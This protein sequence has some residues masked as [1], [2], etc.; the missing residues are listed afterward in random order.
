MKQEYKSGFAALAGRPNV[1]KSSLLNAFIGQKLVI[2]SEK[3]Q[4]TRNQLRGILTTGEYQIIWVDTPGLHHP[5][6]LLG[7]Q[8][9]QN[10]Y[11]ALAGV[12]LILWVLDAELGLTP[13]D[14]KVAERLR[15]FDLPVLVVWNKIDLVA[16]G[17]RRPPITGFD[18]VFKVSA[19]TREGLP[20]LLRE[21]VALLPPGPQYYPPDI[22]TDHPEK[23][24]VAEFI[25]E[26]VLQFTQDE[27]PHSVAVQVEQMKERPDGR[28]YIEA[29]IFVERDSQK[30]ILIGAGGQR[31]KQIGA[32][33][34]QNIE[35]LLNTAIFLSLWVKV[36]KNWRNNEAA[37][38]EFGYWETDK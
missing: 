23:F 8:M 35:Q 5:K 24:I 17:W 11:G 12:D 29:V 32:A 6:H 18:R 19:V 7:N 37:L 13:G 4:T 25:R 22:V 15:K 9:V 14:Q 10:T 27:I 36:R 1:G 33:A 26:Q 3:P 16:S 21:I 20:E 31:L 28:I 34:R 38:K 30:G 2:T